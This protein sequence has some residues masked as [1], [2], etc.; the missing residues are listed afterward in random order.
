MSDIP[1]YSQDRESFL[2]NWDELVDGSDTLGKKILSIFQQC[3]Q[4][5]KPE[6]QL[7]VLVGLT[8][9]PTAIV[10][11]APIG[12][13]YG[14][15]GSGKSDLG[16]IIAGCYNVPIL[17]S[18]TTY[19]GL[20]NHIMIYKYYDPDS[21]RYEKHLCVVFDDL[22]PKALEN[23]AIFTL[24]KTGHSRKTALTKIAMVGGGS[25]EFNTFCTKFLTSINPFWE[26]AEYLELKRRCVVFRTQ[27]S[28]TYN[29]IDPKEIDFSGLSV[30]LDYFWRNE[31]QR[32][33]YKHFL[34]KYRKDPNKE[35]LASISCV[36]GMTS[37][38][39]KK[40]FD[41][42]WEFTDT[43]SIGDPLVEFLKQEI[44]EKG[45]DKVYTQHIKLLINNAKA[46]GIIDRANMKDISRSLKALGYKLNS[47]DSN[48][49]WTN[50]ED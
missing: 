28:D 32:T 12:V 40:L 42:F 25:L 24:L 14:P 36:L 38:E 7:P 6:L 27:K 50:K 49:F 41:E 16:V 26:E 31:Q 30:E 5:P 2:D 45:L 39:T 23:D 18:S 21:C 34:S 44:E 8:M 43:H 15:S 35:L 1:D 9:L 47:D 33:V 46:Q 3:T 17:S 13:A 19:A 20:R 4:L 22:G 29:A 48:W 11:T 10:N 37:D